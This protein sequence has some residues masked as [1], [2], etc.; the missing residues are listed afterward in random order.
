M[1]VYVG[2]DIGTATPTEE[3]SAAVSGTTWWTCSPPSHGVGV[4]EFQAVAQA[5][6]DDVRSRDAVPSS[7]GAASLYVS[8]V[9][10]DLRFQAPTPSSGHGWRANSPW[11]A[12][13]RCTTS[14]RGGR[15]GRCGGD[16]ADERSSDRPCT[17]GDR[18]DRRS[19]RRDA[20][21][22]PWTSITVRIG[23]AVPPGPRRADRGTRR[24]DEQT[25]SSTRC[26][27]LRPTGW[28]APRPPRGRWSY[29]QVLAY[30]AGE[31]DEEPGPAADG[32]RDPPVRPPAAAMVRA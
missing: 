18:Y 10:D 3:R 13:R 31:I 8:T 7:S 22:T 2:M 30:L 32:R 5:V 20:A 24:R 11:S 1:Q 19:V 16:P 29:Q 17:R 27:A 26:A 4:A 15:P 12:R 21:P 6:I 14:P 25:G 28:R 9:L 23:L